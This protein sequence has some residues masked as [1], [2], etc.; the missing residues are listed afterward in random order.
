MQRRPEPG[1]ISVSED[2]PLVIWR[3]CDGKRG[4]ENQTLGLAE[5]LRERVP[6][7]TH[8]IDVHQ[9]GRAPSTGTPSLLLGAGHR[10]HGAV[11]RTRR[12]THARAVILMKPSL[13]RGRFDLCVV[14]EHDGLRAQPGVLLTRGVLNRVR[15]AAV[16]HPGAGLIAIGGP[17]KHHD[18]LG[19]EIV[20]Q[21]KSIIARS[22]PGQSWTVTNSRRTPQDTWDAITAL[23][24]ST[25]TCVD[26]RHQD[27][28]WL[29]G[30]LA[31]AQTVWVSEDS[32]S[33]VY[34]ALSAGAG[35]GLLAV[36]RRSTGRVVR[37]ITF[38]IADQSVTPFGCWQSGA[39]LRPPTVALNEAGRVA[40]WIESQWLQLA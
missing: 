26:W 10:T 35:V 12:R 34:E 27:P 22:A 21:I 9:S 29:V 5:A 15:P 17:S 4:H 40:D 6:V 13:A 11:W 32:V 24:S 38:L 1:R 31:T 30:Q 36:P 7:R 16:K 33:M 20:A 3:F 37:G 19:A 18:W 39:A 8:D 2:N 14:P 23:T 25:M 28:S